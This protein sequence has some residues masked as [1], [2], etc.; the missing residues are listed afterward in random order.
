MDWKDGLTATIIVGLGYL[1]YQTPF[2]RKEMK[3]ASADVLE[4]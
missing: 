1:G 4:M 3:W 2:L